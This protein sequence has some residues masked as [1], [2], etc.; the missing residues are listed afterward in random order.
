[1]VCIQ[2]ILAAT[3]FS[4]DAQ[5]AAERAAIIA[6]AHEVSQ[7]VILH[8]LE[9]SWLDTLKHFVNLP[10]EAERSL[11]IDASR[12]LDQLIAKIQ[13]QT[14]FAFE[15]RVCVG[16]VLDLILQVAEDFDLLALGARGENP[17]RDVTIG[18]TAERLIRQSRKPILVV[19]N[20]AKTTYQ[21]VL[22]AVDFSPNSLTAFAYS[23]V[24]APHSEIYLIHIFE[25]LFEGKML[26]AGVRDEI[27][28]EYRINARR[29]AE[30]EMRRFIE[31]SG[32][33]RGNIYRF[34]EHG[35]HVPSKLL[36]KAREISADL[37]IVGKHGKSLVEQLLLGSVTLHLLRECP[38]DV[39]VAQ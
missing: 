26:Y 39:L 9:S 25:A 5:Y 1:M 13:Q 27:I 31:A 20:E 38:C 28:Q 22:V 6:A 10:V 32:V 24:I 23:N 17:L 12:S 21:R 14:G 15:S 19:R 30:A 37:V 8:V 34:I 35:H 36:D 7:G 16:N 2:S 11:V 33:E 18:T 3:D 4:V 29:E